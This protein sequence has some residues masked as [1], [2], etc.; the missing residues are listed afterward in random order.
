MS[1]EG[2]L[3]AALGP[4]E[5]VQTVVASATLGT[6]PTQIALPT[7]ASGRRR[8]VRVRITNPN[9]SNFIAWGLV[10]KGAAA[11]SIVATFGAGAGVPV[12]PRDTYEFSLYDGK[13]L[14]VVADAAAMSVSVAMFLF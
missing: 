9:A 6:T 2:Y 7:D 5:S 8:R 11:P 14:Y 10:E 12:L 3:N 13:D 4:L 1:M